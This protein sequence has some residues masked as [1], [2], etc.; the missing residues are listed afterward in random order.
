LFFFSL[1]SFFFWNFFCP[2]LAAPSF[3]ITT[4][5]SWWPPIPFTS[6]DGFVPFFS[7]FFD[8]SSNYPHQIVTKGRPRAAAFFSFPLTGTKPKAVFLSFFESPLPEILR[9]PAQFDGI[10]SFSKFRW[11]P[12]GSHLPVYIPEFLCL[13]YLL[14]FLPQYTTFQF[15][16]FF[17]TP[18]LAKAQ[19]VRLFF[20]DSF[21]PFP[22]R[23][24][25]TAPKV[26]ISPAHFRLFVRT[27]SQFFFSA[28]HFKPKS[29][30]HWLL[31][32]LTLS[33]T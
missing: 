9:V 23:P 7:L 14:N 3:S 20:F 30:S 18:P 21:P 22:S 13:I 2:I 24:P 1:F 29:I 27:S 10:Q 32:F 31:S 12:S 33:A 16:F 11:V 19:P 28:V 6:D 8:V 25:S 26:P 4:V 15:G 5:F 17:L